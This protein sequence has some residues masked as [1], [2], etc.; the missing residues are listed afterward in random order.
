MMLKASVKVLSVTSI[1]AQF[2][3]PRNFFFLN[4]LFGALFSEQCKTPK[5]K[6]HPTKSS[7]TRAITKQEDKS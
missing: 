7:Q 6:L 4:F 3:Y 2:L 1:L 5:Q